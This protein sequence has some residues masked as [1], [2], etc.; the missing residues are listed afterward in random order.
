MIRSTLTPVGVDGLASVTVITGCDVGGGFVLL[1]G[2]ILAWS[3]FLNVG[4]VWSLVEHPK[5]LF[6]VAYNKKIPF[7]LMWNVSRVPRRQNPGVGRNTEGKGEKSNKC[8]CVP[9]RD[10]VEEVV[11]LAYPE[12]ASSSIR[13]LAAIIITDGGHGG[14]T[15]RQRATISAD[16]REGKRAEK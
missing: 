9:G 16:G 14:A 11:W 13:Q 15:E 12:A 7:E 3:F 1:T 8:V 2:D 4:I 5:Y 6:R 10:R